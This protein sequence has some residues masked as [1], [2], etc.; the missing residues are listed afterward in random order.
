MLE[1]FDEVA[2]LTRAVAA[3]GLVGVGDCG[4]RRRFRRRPGNWHY[5]IFLLFATLMMADDLGR[6]TFVRSGNAVLKMYFE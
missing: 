1:V 5:Q 6:E 3:G 4:R 2:W